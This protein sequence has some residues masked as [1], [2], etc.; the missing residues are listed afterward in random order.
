MGWVEVLYQ[1]FPQ[2][3]PGQGQK[4]LSFKAA[5]GNSRGMTVPLV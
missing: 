1:R 3:G 5:L 2:Y 4:S